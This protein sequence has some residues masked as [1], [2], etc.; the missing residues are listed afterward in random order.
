MCYMLGWCRRIDEPYLSFSF[1]KILLCCR[2]GSLSRAENKKW[3]EMLDFVGFFFVSDTLSR[4]F[5]FKVEYHIITILIGGDCVTFNTGAVGQMCAFFFFKVILLNLMRDCY[6]RL[7]GTTVGFPQDPI[8]V[9]DVKNHDR[10]R[11]SH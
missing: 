1:F 4:P 3:K 9:S 6:R 7:R 8:A 10:S 2:L 11:W 5:F